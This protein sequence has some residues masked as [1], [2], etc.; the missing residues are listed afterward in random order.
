MQLHNALGNRMFSKHFRNGAII[1]MQHTNR[2]S[3]AIWEEVCLFID[4]AGA[5]FP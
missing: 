3:I 2:K 5:G 1:Y 4:F